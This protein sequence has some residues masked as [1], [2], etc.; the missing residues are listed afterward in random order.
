M[1]ILINEPQCTRCGACASFCPIDAIRMEGIPVV[2][3]E[4]CME[5]GACISSC[6]TQAIS[7]KRDM[8]VPPRR[9]ARPLPTP[10]P[11]REPPHRSAPLVD[12][13]ELLSRLTLGWS[14]RLSGGH[15]GKRR[16]TAE[17][18]A[19]WGK[20]LREKLKIRR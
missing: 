10:E 4:T 5:C 6:P 1:P 16:H 18:S 12:M 13:E 20:L 19:G 3:E 7:L 11:R 2:N 8:N 17:F 14:R 9:A 15:S